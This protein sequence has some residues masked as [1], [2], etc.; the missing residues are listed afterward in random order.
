MKDDRDAAPDAVAE[1]LRT[2]LVSLIKENG[3]QPR[4]GQE[5]L[6]AAA[7]ARPVREVRRMAALVGEHPQEEAE[8]H[9]TLRAAAVGRPVEDVALRVGI[10]GAEGTEGTEG[11]ERAGGSGLSGAGRAGPGRPG[12]AAGPYAHPPGAAAPAGAG[13]P[14]GPAVPARPAVAPAHPPGSRALRHVL[15]WPVAVALLFC[16]ALHLPVDAA[17]LP[18]MTPAVAVLCLGLGAVLAVRDTPVVWRSVAVAALGLVTLHVWGGI[19]LFDPL[20][21]AVGGPLPW[22]GTTAV[23]SA[24]ACSVL[25]GVALTYRPARAGEASHRA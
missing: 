9:I 12:A 11:T 18:L 1:P 2:P 14:A 4:H 19:T 16:G 7:V 23:L 15:R 20:D 10:L 13:W 21:G 8:A 24:A 25:A 22:A 3:R 17:A 6:R 5:A